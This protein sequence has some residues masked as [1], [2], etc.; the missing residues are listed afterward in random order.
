MIFLLNKIN[1]AKSFGQLFL[2]MILSVLVSG[3]DVAS[4]DSAGA[5]GPDPGVFED[6]K[7]VV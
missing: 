1:S 5:T 6:R 4:T 7:S 2:A 3:C